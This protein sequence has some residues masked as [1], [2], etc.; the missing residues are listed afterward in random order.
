MDFHTRH[1]HWLN[2]ML[3]VDI[4]DLSVALNLRTVFDFL[5]TLH[6]PLC[7]PEMSSNHTACITGFH[8]LSLLAQKTTIIPNDFVCGENE[9]IF[10]LTGVNSGGKTTFLR[11]LG[12]AVTFFTAGL[13]VPAVSA[14]LPCYDRLEILFAGKQTTR[15][16]E[17]FQREKQA[18]QEAVDILGD[19]S[20][21][22]V[23]EIFSSLDEKSAMAEYN[24]AIR[25]LRQKNTRCLFITHLHHLAQ[26][27]A[28]H[29]GI[30]NLMA[31]TGDN[32][33]RLYIIKRARGRTSNV[34]EILH[35]YALTPALLR[36]GRGLQ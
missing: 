31:L 33:E 30:V 36:A 6:I 27:A 17:R 2:Q 15:V 7:F 23:N 13:P 4:N 19:S 12:A 34:A 14:E 21:L 24:H 29:A 3:S 32:N 8:D 10:I 9:K 18:V 26:G 16:G 28:S 22:L 25:Q 11:A 20:L 35:A 5:K 1:G